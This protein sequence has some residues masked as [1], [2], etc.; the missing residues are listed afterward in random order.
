M[1]T[2]CLVDKDAPAEVKHAFCSTM[3]LT[4]GP[5][6]VFEQDDIN[7]WQQCTE[8][9]K[10]PVGRQHLSNLAMGIGHQGKRSELIPGVLSPTS[11]SE[12]NQRA[13][14]AR[15]AEIMDAPNWG[16]ISITPKTRL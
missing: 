5:A 7:N 15:W 2:D 16:H 8:S 12:Q 3:A 1:W 6:G 14:Y 13:F 11:P 4:F 10:T 9:A